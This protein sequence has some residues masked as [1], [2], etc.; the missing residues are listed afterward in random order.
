M[1]E[2][3]EHPRRERRR[4]HRRRLVLATVLGAVAVVLVVTAVATVAAQ[5]PL[6]GAD[7]SVGTSSE[8]EDVTVRA[9]DRTALTSEQIAALPEARY[10]AVVAGL[11]PYASAEVPEVSHAVYTIS[12]DTPIYN[13]AHTPVA[14]F[15]FLNFAGRPTVIVPVRADGLW[16]LVM[17]PARQKLPSE[18]NGLA[19]AQTAGWVHTDALHRTSTLA[20]RVVISTGEQRLRIENFAGTVEQSFGVGVGAPGTPTPTG[21]TGYL[22]ERY[23][24]SQQ[25]QTT[26]P[27]Q[28]TSLHASTK[29]EPFQGEDGGLIGMHYFRSNSGSISH[30]CIRLSEEAVTAVD[31]LPLGTSVTIV[32]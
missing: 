22:Q 5:S 28:L 16:T 10:D 26:Y 20:S 8:G 9:A 21:V 15:A 27:I 11:L 12:S 17:T 24:D 3:P 4:R 2:L 1:T 6:R 29:D 13:D 32:P 14:R 31:A 19:P 23:L 30:G 7:R 18:A 25:G